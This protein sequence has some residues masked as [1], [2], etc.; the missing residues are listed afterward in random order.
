MAKE[1]G[2]GWTTCSVDNAA[3]TLKAIVND[4][5]SLEFST[6]RAVIE[7]T[8]LDVSAM[9]RLHG[10]ADFSATLNFTFND[11]TDRVHD[12]FKDLSSVRTF[13]L[14]VSGQ[15]LSNEVLFTDYAYNRGTDGSLTGTAP[16]VLANGV[17]PT[18]S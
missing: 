18:W 9:E 11:A 6:P 15:T 1:N 5:N 12:V 4:V 17:V 16:C 8:G 3:G 2:L 10:L 13:T 7:T 14:V